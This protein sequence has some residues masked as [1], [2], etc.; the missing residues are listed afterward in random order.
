[1]AGG[2]GVVWQDGPWEHRFVPANG[3][4]FHVVLAGPESGE[5][6]VLLHGFPQFWWAWRHQLTALA[7][8][9][10]RVAAMDI[11][12]FGGSD[13]PPGGHAT[14]VLTADVGGV[15]RSLGRERA[16]VVG[17]SFGG[18][19]G[20]SM[21]VL[22]PRVTRAVAVLSA[23]HPL[24]LLRLRNHLGARA[25]AFLARVQVPWFPEQALRR[26]DLVTRVLTDLSA[27][28]RVL[29]PEELRAYQAAVRLP[30]VAHT[31]LEHLRWLVRST[32]R[33]DGRRYLAAM[34]HPVTVPVLS[35]RGGADRFAP[36]AAYAADPAY[37]RGPLRTAVV[38]GAGHLLPEEAPEAVTGLLLDFLAGLPD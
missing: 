4:R 13:K 11:R 23:P 38:P 24:P 16:V 21:P 33:P 29:P 5:L 15:V 8:A 6:V 2:Q 27:P 3:A 7:D 34:A 26:G 22:E 37:V 31:S 12:G 36:A 32:P 20:W 30:S 14:P 10:H 18:I 25:R 9:G 19:L 35:V 17:H 28:G 1:M